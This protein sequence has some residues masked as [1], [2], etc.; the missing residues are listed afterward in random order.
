MQA[1][2]CA[3]AAPFV[4]RSHHKDFAVSVRT[5]SNFINFLKAYVPNINNIAQFDE[6]VVDVAK[7]NNVKPFKFEFAKLSVYKQQIKQAYDELQSRVFLISGQAGD[8]KTHFLRSLCSIDSDVFCLSEKTWDAI[9]E[10]KYQNIYVDDK[11]ELD[12]DKIKALPGRESSKVKNI[13]FNNKPIRLVLITDLTCVNS[14]ADKNDL[15]QVIKDIARNSLKRKQQENHKYTAQSIVSEH[16]MSLGHDYDNTTTIALIAANNGRILKTFSDY[17]LLCTQELKK[18]QKAKLS[19]AADNSSHVALNDLKQEVLYELIKLSKSIERHM[20]LHKVFRSDFMQLMPLSDCLDR[21]AV[22]EILTKVLNSE[23][24]G[25]CQECNIRDKCPIFANRNALNSHNV[26]RHF[27]DLFELAKD[28][29]MHFTVRNIMVVVCNAILGNLQKD[30]DRFYT[31]QKAENDVKRFFNNDRRSSPF[32]NLLGLNLNSKQFNLIDLDGD[33]KAN[34]VIEALNTPPIFK[35]LESFGVGFNSNKI[36]DD[37]IVKA[38][39][40]PSSDAAHKLNELIGIS[41][42]AAQIKEK[43]KQ[44]IDCA[45]NSVDSDST[46]NAELYN[47]AMRSYIASMRRMLF[48]TADQNVDNAVN[49]GSGVSSYS[50]TELKYAKAYLNFKNLVRHNIDLSNGDENTPPSVLEQLIDGLNRVFTSLSVMSSNDSVYISSN[51][52]INPAEFCIVQDK[53]RFVLKFVK[54]DSKFTDVVRIVRS[55]LF[56]DVNDLPTLAYYP[57]S[58]YWQK[59]SE[60]ANSGFNEVNNDDSSTSLSQEIK[61]HIIRTMNDNL[62][63]N[64]FCLSRSPSFADSDE[65]Q[66]LKLCYEFMALKDKA[67]NLKEELRPLFAKLNEVFGKT[68][69]GSSDSS[70]EQGYSMYAEYTKFNNCFPVAAVKLILSPRIF[71]Y[72]MSIGA[73]DSSISFSDECHEELTSFKTRIEAFKSMHDNNQ[74]SNEKQVIEKLK[75]CKV[76]QDGQVKLE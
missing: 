48:F 46:A 66:K 39:L 58:R 21:A 9:I 73:G 31:C 17:A 41:S 60:H 59:L 20:I 2:S 28:D 62:E 56:D 44:S 34:D 70:Q 19:E 16:D 57:T 8:G 5:A 10:D 32:D 61:D 38:C 71:N 26:I 23:H 37:F 30:N 4:F 36:I 29:G 11:G 22:E 69:E 14:D 75:F 33:Q 24:W 40:Y 52:I 6:H 25:K 43:L 50:L 27:A 42:D 15:L 55:G 7:K 65:T 67:K 76:D 72:L 68:S 74:N 3:I 12:L 1:L 54:D 45:L 49:Y 51:N 35:Q 18:L 53:D 64:G 47:E 63:F 13:F